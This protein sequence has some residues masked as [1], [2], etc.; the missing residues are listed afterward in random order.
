M[1]YSLTSLLFWQYPSCINNFHQSNS[2]LLLDF[3]SHWHF[4]KLCH[5]S[6]SQWKWVCIFY[7]IPHSH[8]FYHSFW[9]SACCRLHVRIWF[10][11]LCLCSANLLIESS[12]LQDTSL[13]SKRNNHYYWK[14]NLGQ[15]HYSF[16]QCYQ[17]KRSIKSYPF[18]QHSYCRNQQ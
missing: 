11:N 3:K 17:F 10:W 1:E 18:K 7:L 9:N 8:Q 16:L 5:G 4:Q 13:C 2:N 12:F 15:M 14:R 6:H